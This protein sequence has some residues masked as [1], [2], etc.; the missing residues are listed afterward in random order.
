ME[1]QPNTGNG[2]VENQTGENL[3]GMND[4]YR[5]EV[6]N[7]FNSA[8]DAGDAEG[9]YR[10]LDEAGIHVDSVDD[11]TDEQCKELIE[12][13][14]VDN[15]GDQNDGAAASADNRDG[16][17]VVSAENQ[18]SSGERRVKK[19]K[20]VGVKSATVAV[21]LGTVIGSVI[22][23]NAAKALFQKDAD[24]SKDIFGK[25]PGQTEAAAGNW[26]DNANGVNNQ[27]NADNQE[28]GETLEK[29][30]FRNDYIYYNDSRKAVPGERSAKAFCSEELLGTEVFKKLDPETQDKIRQ[31]DWEGKSD[32]FRGMIME[33]MESADRTAISYTF[34]VFAEK[35]VGEKFFDGKFVGK[36]VQ[37][38][39][40]IIENMDEDEADKF[41]REWQEILEHAEFE[42]VICTSDKNHNHFIEKEK[43]TNGEYEYELKHTYTDDEGAEILRIH[44]KDKD[45]DGNWLDK[46]L[47]TR[48][49]KANISNIEVSENDKGEVTLTFKNSLGRVVYYCMQ[50]IIE[51]NGS[52]KIVVTIPTIPTP[53]GESKNAKAALKNAGENA[54]PQP[55]GE[56]TKKPQEEDHYDSDKGKGDG[57]EEHQE[58][59]NSGSG[60]TA[61]GSVDS[62]KAPVSDNKDQTIDQAIDNADKSHNDDVHKA[63]SGG[64]DGGSSN[65]TPTPKP[66]PTQDNHSGQSQ[67]NGQA[68]SDR[69]EAKALEDKDVTMA[70]V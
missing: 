45:A 10:L 3:E 33:N 20:K 57:T 24:K 26:Q 63:P 56:Q 12:R 23:A 65:K 51:V 7:A 59:S 8:V 13:W 62:S 34:N 32:L 11:L 29:L 16:G 53:D 39:E 14:M 19:D 47:V 27:E 9:F 6:M 70:D 15:N 5:N 50:M 35:G 68:R 60:D 61:E 1:N 44:F 4:I 43:Q 54:D 40:A 38:I 46:D 17:G 55:A 30:K 22:G 25:Q 52:Y 36:S 41:L 21:L 37:E 42:T 58:Q 64:N 67:A 18:D 28:E 48:D 31:G 66:K 49:I 69:D 2:G